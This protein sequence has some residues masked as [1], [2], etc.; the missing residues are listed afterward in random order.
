MVA[1]GQCTDRTTGERGRAGNAAPVHYWSAGL[2]TRRAGAE[3]WTVSIPPSC[4]AEL[5]GA[6]AA[7]RHNQ[8]PLFLLSPA[9]FALERC[10]ALLRRIRAMLDDGIMFAVLDRLPM[11]EMS[12]EESVM[13]Y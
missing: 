3:D 11:D 5:R 4:L 2:D 13:L 7:L 1:N 9:D 6:L 10:R 8:L 12:R